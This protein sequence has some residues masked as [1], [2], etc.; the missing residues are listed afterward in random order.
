MSFISLTGIRTIALYKGNKSHAER[1]NKTV[2]NQ[3]QRRED[4][5]EEK[6]K[7]IGEKTWLS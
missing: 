4:L 2:K 1:E 7:Q 5:K 3:F 6:S